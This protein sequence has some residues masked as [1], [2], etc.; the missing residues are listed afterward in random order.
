M[1]AG[2]R[3]LACLLLVA[4]WGVAAAEDAVAPNI[5]LWQKRQYVREHAADY[6]NGTLRHHVP[7]EQM[8]QRAL[9]MPGLTESDRT[10]INDAASPEDLRACRDTIRQ[11]YESRS[12]YRGRW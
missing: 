2:I 5:P 7:L 4:F 9:Q 8:K 11:R 1:K 12:G 10:C 6:Q 3:L